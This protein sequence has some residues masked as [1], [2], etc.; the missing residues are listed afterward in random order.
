MESRSSFSAFSPAEGV[1]CWIMGTVVSAP[2]HLRSPVWLLYS[3][4]FCYTSFFSIYGASNFFIASLCAI[5]RSEKSWFTV[6]KVICMVKKTTVW[7]KNEVSC[8]ESRCG[9]W[10]NVISVCIQNHTSSREMG[11]GEYMTNLCCGISATPCSVKCSHSEKHS[12]YH[13]PCY[14]T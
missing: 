3:C 6:F 8:S 14:F 11:E 10:A 7:K 12:C 5:S 13:H 2:S 9:K 4:T 1:T